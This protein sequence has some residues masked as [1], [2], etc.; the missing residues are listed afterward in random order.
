MAVYSSDELVWCRVFSFSLKEEALDWFHS[1]QPGTI[2]NF[3]ELRQLF[4]QQY[5]A[6]KTPGMT[7]TALVRLRQGR[8]ESLKSFM[9]RFSRTARQVRNADQRLIVSALTTALRPGPFCDYLHAEEPQSMDELQNRLA[10][11]IRIEEGRA[12]HRGRDD[13]E[14]SVRAV[15][16]GIEHPVSRRDR[17][18][19]LRGKDRSR[20]QRYIHHTPLNAPRTRV[21]EEALR[22]DLIAVVQV[23]TPARAD[24]SKHCRYHQNRGHTTE[25][26]ITLK[27]KLEAL[28]QA[29][30]LQR[31]VQRRGST[32]RIRPPTTQR[33]PQVRSQQRTDR[34]R[35]R[36]AE[37]VVRGVINTI[38]G[39]FAGGG[40][41]SAARKRHLRNLHSSN[42]SGSSRRSMPAITF[43]DEDFH[44]P[45]LEQDDPMV[46][47]AMIARYQVSKVLVDQG[48]SANIL[49]WKTF[50]QMEIS[51][52]AIMPFNE[53]IVGF[54]GKGWTQKGM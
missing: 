42:R 18:A 27:D 52:D 50:K 40:S 33:N 38:S 45:D 48:S 44:A 35:S 28:V 9:D 25:D 21:L 29:G 49:Y 17:G 19:G 2:G 53:Q 14:S 32:G 37:R 11:F 22:A 51:E 47:T 46:I 43:T 7:Y 8:D 16:G 6:N 12:H 5:A 30:H 41:T 23:P 36:S 54:A 26:C 20:M 31:F 4:T 1:L 39:G 24:E 3:A 13:G 34:S 10:S 15:R